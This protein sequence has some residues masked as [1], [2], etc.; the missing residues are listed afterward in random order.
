MKKPKRVERCVTHH[1]CD[2]FAWK[3]EQMENALRIIEVWADWAL[4]EARTAKDLK[5]MLQD[6]ND[7]A[8]ETLELL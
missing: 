1:Y 7:K 4:T 5:K 3:F 2:C 8:A 6:I